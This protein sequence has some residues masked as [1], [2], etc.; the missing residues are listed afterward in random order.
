MQATY[1]GLVPQSA[2]DGLSVEDNEARK[3]QQLTEGR[4]QT[5]VAEVE[6]Q[7]V[8]HASLGSTAEED[9]EGLVGQ[10][11]AIYIDPAWW[12]QGVGRL[13]WSEAVKRA[14]S[15]GWAKLLVKTATGNAR[16]S[17]FYEAMGC[18]ADPSSVTTREYLGATVETV[19]YQVRLLN[20]R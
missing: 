2:L 12:R 8:G 10:L 17:R 15:A 1:R 11:Y 19:T 13:L 16:A 7:V 5:F 6:G 14:R 18:V 9:E 20:S 4:T 3:R